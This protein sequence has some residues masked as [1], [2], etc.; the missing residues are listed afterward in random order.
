MEHQADAPEL[1]KA[2]LLK[3]PAVFKGPA[4]NQQWKQQPQQLPQPQQ[5]AGHSVN[6]T[7]NQ[8]SPASYGQGSPGYTRHTPQGSP[9]QPAS[10]RLVVPED[11]SR[12]PQ[13]SSN[14]GFHE[15]NSIPQRASVI[16]GGLEQNRPYNDLSENKLNPN[17][18]KH[19]SENELF[20]TDS[21]RVGGLHTDIPDYNR[22]EVHPSHRGTDNTLQRTDFATGNFQPISSNNA[23]DL[24]NSMRNFR[25][26][27][28]HG[29]SS[30]EPYANSLDQRLLP[31]LQPGN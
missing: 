3:N 21:Q 1:L 27:K 17:W 18:Q 28:T 26:Q 13:P 16:A 31:T 11:K 23:N 2:I 5:Q 29:Q 4:R 12:P 7:F 22:P 8:S 14:I 15:P 20:S 19:K 30:Q 24:I 6:S 9:A 10:A 25:P